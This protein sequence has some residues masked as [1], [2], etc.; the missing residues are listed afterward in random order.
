MADEALPIFVRHRVAEEAMACRPA[1][2]GDR[3]GTGAGRRRKNAAM[4]RERGGAL[5]QFG[6]KRR[7]LGV[8]QIGAQAVADDDDGPRKSTGSSSHGP[9]PLSAKSKISKLRN[10]RDSDIARYSADTGCDSSNG[11]VCSKAPPCERRRWPASADRSCSAA[12]APITV[13][14]SPV[15]TR[16]ASRS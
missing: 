5:R 10:A 4:R 16:S 2:G 1:A 14:R 12:L 15:T 9:T 6:E 7:R 11:T 13:L 8:D 3:G